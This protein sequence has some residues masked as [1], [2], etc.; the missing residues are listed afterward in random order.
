[1]AFEN[2]FVEI[3]A[4][5]SVLVETVLVL[6]LLMGGC[7]G[8]VPWLGV[9]GMCVGSTVADNRGKFADSNRCRVP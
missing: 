5:G 9:S 8:W 3:K 2:G 4:V 6:I 7:R 1:M